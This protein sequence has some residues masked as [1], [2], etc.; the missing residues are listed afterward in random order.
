MLVLM[1][2]HQPHRTLTNLRRIPLRCA[3]HDSILSRRG[4]CNFPGAVQ[5]FAQLELVCECADDQC[6]ERLSVP[7]DE[8]ELIRTRSD[9][10]V[11]SPGH[12]VPEIEETV[13]HFNG[14]LVVEKVGLAGEVATRLDPRSRPGARNG[15]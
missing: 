14:Y 12:Q 7:A 4:A 8:Y 1:L 5:N 9:H 6:A 3:R 11:I 15:T 10:F 13:G 2:E